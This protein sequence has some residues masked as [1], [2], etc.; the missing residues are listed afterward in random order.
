MRL[1]GWLDGSERCLVTQMWPWS[2]AR[3]YTLDTPAPAL[4][5]LTTRHST[6][7]A[8]KSGS[9]QTY[10]QHHHNK[11]A[12]IFIPFQASSQK[13]HI[14]IESFCL[15][16]NRIENCW[17]AAPMS[18]A[19]PSMKVLKQQQVGQGQHDL[20]VMTISGACRHTSL[21]PAIGEHL[22]TD[23]VIYIRYTSLV[24][25]HHGRLVL[26]ISLLLNLG[27]QGSLK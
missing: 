20:T 8:F 11:P 22:G 3:W 26:P 14:F 21:N 19:V 24:S 13:L 27:F 25:I 1:V 16:I 12:R 15:C 4:L 2:V 6:S 17:I 5:I 10:P 23:S 18:S 7:W 9:K